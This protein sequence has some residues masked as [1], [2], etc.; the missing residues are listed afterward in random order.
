M[1]LTRK[2]CAGLP[3]LKV[4]AKKYMVKKVSLPFFAVL[5]SHVFE[6]PQK[7]QCFGL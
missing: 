6:I 3:L 2:R 7:E 5:C 4:I 1:A